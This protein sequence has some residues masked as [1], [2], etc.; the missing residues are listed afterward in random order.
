MAEDKVINSP[1]EF[2]EAILSIVATSG[3]ILEQGVLSRWFTKAK[4]WY[5]PNI[6]SCRKKGLTEG[7]IVQEYKSLVVMHPVEKQKIQRW[8]DTRFVLHLNGEFVGNL[9]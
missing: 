9:P 7:T 4:N 8:C 6:C 2:I 3:K 5:D 1:K